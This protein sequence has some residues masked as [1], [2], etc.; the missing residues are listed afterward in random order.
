[1]ATRVV[2]D[3]RARLPAGSRLVQTVSEA[4]LLLVTTGAKPADLIA[5]GVELLTLAGENRPAVAALLDE[6][7]RRRMTNLLVEGGGAVL[8]S[9]RDAG[10]VDEVH[11][12]IAPMLIGGTAAKGPVGGDGADRLADAFRLSHWEFE[13]IGPDLL[14]HGWR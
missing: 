1:V 14:W 12:F 8:G 10:A 13:R 11:V 7:G 3:S 4:P 2:L 5:Q 6:L 9:F